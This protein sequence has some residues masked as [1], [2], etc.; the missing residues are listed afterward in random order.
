M[1]IRRVSTKEYNLAINQQLIVLLDRNIISRI[2]SV[3]NPDELITFKLRY[4]ANNFSADPHDIVSPALY[5]IESNA[6]EA[7]LYEKFQSELDTAIKILKKVVEIRFID[8]SY[9]LSPK[10][11]YSS[12]VDFYTDQLASE[13]D[14]LISVAG[15]ISHPCSKSSLPS[16]VSEIIHLADI[17]GVKKRSILVIAVL[18]CLHETNDSQTLKSARR[19][20]KP[21][22]GYSLS[23]AYNALSDLRAL[24]FMLMMNGITRHSPN[25]L[26]QT[27]VIDTGD[28]HLANFSSLLGLSNP[29]WKNDSLLTYDLSPSKELFPVLTTPEFDS[30]MEMLA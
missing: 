23:D 29:L 19:L 11:T 18:S 20:L 15:I 28:Q 9:N 22:N 6:R 13:S 4:G 25:G 2:N 10:K 3:T 5:C 1:N 26:R 21:K 7:P 17:S 12:F 30:L 24:M 27:V 8:C 16:L 14:F